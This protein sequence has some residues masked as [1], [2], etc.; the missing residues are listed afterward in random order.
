[1]V[2]DEKISGNIELLN[3]SDFRLFQLLLHRGVI[4]LKILLKP[5]F[6]HIL[7]MEK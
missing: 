5:L 7:N 3:P 1:M 2:R 6:A 4:D